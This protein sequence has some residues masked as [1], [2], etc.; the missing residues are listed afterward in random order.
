MTHNPDTNFSIE[1]D[2]QMIE[3][4]NLQ[5]KTFKKLI[6]T[7]FKYN[8]THEHSEDISERYKNEPSGTSW[9]KKIP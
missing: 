3:M 8:K 4:M 1:T 9:I 7:T 5:S 2:Q 6:L